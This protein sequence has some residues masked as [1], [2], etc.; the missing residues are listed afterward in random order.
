MA[1][2]RRDTPDGRWQVYGWRQSKMELAWRLGARLAKDGARFGEFTDFGAERAYWKGG[3]LA[4]RSAMRHALRATLLRIPPPR[5]AEYFHLSWMTERHFRCALPL[6]GAVLWRGGVPRYQFL[7]TRAVPDATPMDRWLREERDPRARAAVIDEVARETARMH[8]LRFVHRDLYPRNLVV[9]APEAGRR[10]AF[11]D[12][13]RGGERLQTRGAA[14]DIGCF[15]LHAHQDLA[16]D[17]Q[18]RFWSRYLDERT[19]QGRPVGARWARDVERART[20][21]RSKLAR[22]PARLR[23]REMPAADWRA[24][25][26]FRP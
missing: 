21:E 3:P 7:A 14:H 26:D 24:P 15:L 11:L 5:L 17:E 2:L 1:E 20:R 22:D 18:R 4:P 6:A 23:G 8:A 25:D 19:A 10:V 12:A 13:W 9:A 16:R